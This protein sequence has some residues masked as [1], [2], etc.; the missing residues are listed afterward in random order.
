MIKKLLFP[1]FPLL[2]VGCGEN[3]NKAKVGGRWHTQSKVDG[4]HIV[5]GK[6]GAECH[7]K[8]AQ[9]TFNWKQIL[10]DGSYPLPPLNGSAH[11]WHHS[12][13]VQ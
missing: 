1:V 9:G 6:S 2:T 7:G 11:T 3:N 10:P 5:F 13:S 4:G 12:L 8:N